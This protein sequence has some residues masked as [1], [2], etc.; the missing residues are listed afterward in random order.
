[1]NE[2]EL[3]NVAYS[4]SECLDIF[5]QPVGGNGLVSLAHQLMAAN[6]NVSNGAQHDCIDQTITDADDLIGDLVVPPIGT[7]CLDPADVSALVSMLTSYNQ[8]EL[9]APHCGTER[10]PPFLIER[11]LGG[12]QQ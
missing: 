10:G 6:L 2:L 9:C 3:G 12:C 8:G 1:V 4:E 11:P 5:N 7:G